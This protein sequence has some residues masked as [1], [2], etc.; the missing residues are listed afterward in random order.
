M[1]EKNCLMIF[2]ENLK[3]QQVLD[4]KKVVRIEPVVEADSTVAQ[5]ELVEV[6][7]TSLELVVL[8]C[9][10]VLSK[11]YLV[12]LETCSLARTFEGQVLVEL[13]L[14]CLVCNFAGASGNYDVL[15]SIFTA[16]QG[17]LYVALPTCFNA[18]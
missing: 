13:E 2:L 7:H 17:I 11:F 12:L 15:H 6:L 9:K 10:Q 3:K 5:M 8:A 14:G 16:A 18:R 1:A 4:Q